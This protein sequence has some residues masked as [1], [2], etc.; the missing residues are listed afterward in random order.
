MQ[1]TN[2]SAPVKRPKGLPDAPTAIRCGGCDTEFPLSRFSKYLRQLESG[3]ELDPDEAIPQWCDGC[4]TYGPPLENPLGDLT[5]NQL[6]GMKMLAGGASI[7][8]T[9]RH[10]KIDRTDLR[11]M[12]SGKDRGVFRA[13]YQRLL[14]A[15][16]IDPESIATVIAE[17]MKATRAQWHRESGGFVEF[18]DHSNRLKAAT[19]AQK[20][21]DLNPPNELSR[22]PGEMASGV[23]IFLNTNLGE[24]DERTERDVYTIESREI[25]G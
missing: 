18:P 5:P 4:A 15:K 13:A 3:I 2:P 25:D 24:R 6:A 8:A 20:T 7:A 9:A 22:P 19:I 12:L 11:R 23:N 10:M 17:G 14:I 21:L 1:P 16:G